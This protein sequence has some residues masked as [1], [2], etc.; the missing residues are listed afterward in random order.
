MEAARASLQ[1]CGFALAHEHIVL[2]RYSRISFRPF[3]AIS[4][5]ERQPAL[6]GRLKHE[7]VI[8][9]CPYIMKHKGVLAE[10]HLLYAYLFTFFIV[11]FR[12]Q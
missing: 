12:Q 6:G 2:E 10:A 9:S 11:H 5:W 8:R 1:H 3:V 7:F 4:P